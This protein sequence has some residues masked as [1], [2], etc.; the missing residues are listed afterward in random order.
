MHHLEEFLKCKF[1]GPFKYPFFILGYKR[2]DVQ[3][4]LDKFIAEPTIPE[5][6]KALARK[7]KQG[8]LATKEEMSCMEGYATFR[9]KHFTL[10][11]TIVP[12]G[13]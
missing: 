11:E 5:G 1:K 6:L 2:K 9:K 7:V 13:D 3:S 12:R 4:A 8:T 10:Y